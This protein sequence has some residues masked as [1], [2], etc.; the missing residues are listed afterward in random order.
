MPL[1]SRLGPGYWQGDSWALSAKPWGSPADPQREE[2]CGAWSAW[3]HKGGVARTT[4]APADKHPLGPEGQMD[5]GSQPQGPD[6]HGSLLERVSPTTKLGPVD[7]VLVAATVVAT[8]MPHTIEVGV[9][10]GMVPPA[11]PLVQGTVT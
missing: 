5:R 8:T 6:Q 1:G 3:S 10:T 11:S 2:V 7:P 4:W 9:G